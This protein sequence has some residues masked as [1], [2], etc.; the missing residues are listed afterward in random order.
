MTTSMKKID[1]EKKDVDIIREGTKITLPAK[2]GPMPID[3][4]IYALKRK[5]KD[6]ETEIQVI[7]HIEA[8]PL[9]GAVAFMRAMKRIYGWASPIP[10]PG[11]FGSSPPTMI[12][13][14]TGVNSTKQVIFGRFELPSISGYIETSVSRS[15]EGDVCFTISGEL[16]KKDSHLVDELAR[17]T[18]EIV[19]A[20]SIY[21][22]K[23]LHFRTN[24]KGK[25]DFKVSPTFI[26]TTKTMQDELVLNDDVMEFIETSVFTP[27]K[28][29]ER[30]RQHQI[31]LNRGI[32]LEGIFGVGKTMVAKLAA[33]VCEDNNW[34][35]LMVDKMIA[36]KD[37]LLFAQRYSPAVVFCED[38]DR[39]VSERTDSA[40]DL[41]NT[42]DGIIT[43]DAEVISIMTT[44]HVE[45]INKAMLRPGRL[46]SVI[47]ISP[48]D[49]N[50]VQKLLRVYA[51]GLI[52]EDENLELVGKEL[53]GQI[54]ATI[55]EVVERSKLRGISKINGQG[56][57]INQQD[58]IYASREMKAHLALLNKP[59]ATEPTGYENLIKGITEMATDS[60]ILPLLE[61]I[62]D[63]AGHI[64]K[65]TEEMHERIC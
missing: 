20:R 19:K 8:F 48:P 27:I 64:A 13:V 23:A 17:M 41:L 37:A 6:E 18:R 59:D 36:L 30:C 28:H 40:N 65:D 12:G 29:V 9:D 31:P 11:F 15:P 39:G 54:P 7:E 32:L 42:I 56:I 52:A 43:K 16:R 1:W 5:K 46:D 45:L 35:F 24:D 49:K 53:A 3:E 38:I 2:P 21:K 44:N 61:K 47:T 25:V 63:E 26:D 50:S 60:N 10:T 57:I 22:G 55:R 34:T 14:K 33:K 51:R 62:R 58:L 4:A